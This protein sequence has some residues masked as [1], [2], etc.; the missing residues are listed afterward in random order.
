MRVLIVMPL[1]EQR[2][3]AELA[4][5]QLARHSSEI[6]W[7]IVFLEKGPLVTDCQSSTTET[8]LVPAGRLRN[9]FQ[10]V[11]TVRSIASIARRVQ[12][13]A[14]FGWMSKGHI[15]GGVAALLAGIPALWFQHGL[16]ADIHW[17]DRLASLIPTETVVTC[18][19]AGAHAQSQL[20][21]HQNT[22]VAHPGTDVEWFSPNT[23]PDPTTQRTRLGLPTDVPI[24]AI[25][26][27]LQRWK[28]IHV[29]VDGMDRVV[30]T[31]PEARGVIVGPEHD[32]EPNYLAE[33]NE[34]IQALGLTERID[35][36]GFQSNV[37]EWMHAA[38][39]LVH[40]SDREPF[41]LVVIEALA[42]GKPV[43]ATDTAGPTEIITH[44]ETGLLTPYGDAGALANEILGLLDDPM[45]ADRIAAAGRRRAQD[46][47]VERYVNRI[48]DI[49]DQ[50]IRRTHPSPSTSS[51]KTARSRW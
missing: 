21:P 35:L 12:A 43:I 25:V 50:H 1:A 46:F 11:R 39:I 6:K 15:Y 29:F 51:A 49:L 28:G 7:H 8:H 41:G 42:M 38:D 45:R 24:I 17:I 13:D 16:P 27:R 2:G 3:G 23:L 32:L 19:Q 40:A 47:S 31:Y 48:A 26:G 10:Y 22:M 4:L 20:W 18:S 34:Q 5:T 33:L 44:D 9:L 37:R 14:V 30:Q 36:V